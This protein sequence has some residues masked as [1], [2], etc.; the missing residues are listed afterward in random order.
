LVLGAKKGY[1]TYFCQQ[2]SFGEFQDSLHG[3]YILFFLFGIGMA[4]GLYR[5]VFELLKIVKAQLKTNL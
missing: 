2:I 3:M 1:W 5:I 4:V